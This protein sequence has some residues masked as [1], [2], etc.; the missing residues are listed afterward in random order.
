MDKHVTPQVAH[1][2]QLDWVQQLP[3]TAIPTLIVGPTRSGKTRLAAELI[4]CRE[5]A[6]ST[7]HTTDNNLAGSTHDE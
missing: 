5:L 4:E 6:P 1:E 7:N 2:E 3:R